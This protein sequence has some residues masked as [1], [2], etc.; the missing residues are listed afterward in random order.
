MSYLLTQLSTKKEI[1]EVILNTVD[2]VLVLRFGRA[3][4]SVCMQQDEIVCFT[5]RCAHVLKFV[6]ACKVST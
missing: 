4:D 3:A 6:I 1:D 5:N 2:K